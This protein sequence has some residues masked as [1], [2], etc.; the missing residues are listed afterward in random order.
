M[1]VKH[2]RALYQAGCR[3]D[4]CTAAQRRY[5]RKYRER[6]ANGQTPVSVAP[7]LQV[8]PTERGPVEA[9]VESELTGLASAAARPALVAVAAAMAYAEAGGGKGAGQRDGHAT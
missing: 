5:Q 8:Q 7:V 1:P 2:G 6:R 9:A 3:C 4:E